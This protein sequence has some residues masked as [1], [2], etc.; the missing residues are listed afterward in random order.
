MEKEEIISFLEGLEYH[1]QRIQEDID[2]I[3][4]N[5]IMSKKEKKK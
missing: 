2:R 1:L 5:V 3:K 4:E